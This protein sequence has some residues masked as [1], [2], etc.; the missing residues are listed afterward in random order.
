MNQHQLTRA[1]RCTDCE[2]S[3]TNHCD[4]LQEFVL[5]TAAATTQAGRSYFVQIFYRD[6]ILRRFFIVVS[7]VA[8]TYFTL[9]WIHGCTMHRQHSW[10]I[11]A[12]LTEREA[13]NQRRNP[14]S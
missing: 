6:A 11:K 2:K 8:A 1:R 9:D 12:Y 3:G 4:K 13:A 5:L 14:L 10:A 7:A